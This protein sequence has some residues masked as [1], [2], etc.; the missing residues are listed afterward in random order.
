[1]SIIGLIITSFFVISVE[2]S[3]FR[4]ASFSW[5]P[6]SNGSIKVDYRIS[7]K[8]SRHNC[9]D[10]TI[11]S[12]KKNAEGNVCTTDGDCFKLEYYCTDYSIVDN[13]TSGRNTLY[14]NPPRDK[15][16]LIFKGGDWVVASGWSLLT[17]VDLTPRL[18][19]GLINSSPTVDYPPVVNL[20]Y[21]CQHSIAFPIYD[22]DGDIIRCRWA[23]GK[24]E[25]NSVCRETYN[26]LPSAVLDQN[27][28]KIS[29]TAIDQ[30]GLYPLAIQ[31]EDF[32]ESSP[33]VPLSSIPIQFVVN[34]Y[35]DNYGSCDTVP[36]FVSPTPDPGEYFGV[37][38][39]DQL[40]INITVTG[41]TRLNSIQTT[42]VIGMHRSAVTSWFDGVSYYMSVL[43]TWTPTS[44]A[45]G[46]DHSLCFSG[47]DTNGLYSETRCINIPVGDCG[48]ISSFAN[49]SVH[50][51]N[52]TRHPHMA[53]FDCDVGFKLI[54]DETRQ[55]LANATWSGSYPTCEI[56]ECDD[57]EA[58]KN[59]KI[60]SF[61]RSTIIFECNDGY[62]L[63]GEKILECTINGTW[64]SNPPIC[65][66]GILFNK[67]FTLLYWTTRFMYDFFFIV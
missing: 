64:N 22:V 34:I 1:M 8:R 49:G 46:Q 54:G 27:D 25:C 56:I 6:M 58:P 16:D 63:A 48:D 26:A 47:R 5:A 36:T 61:N 35:S 33:K 55:C 30:V 66:N 39:G 24:T 40:T 43:V 15:F 21:S 44:E 50:T 2:S 7:W 14:I 3:H 13:W 53:I 41:K 67:A 9:D 42:S 57:L 38:V 23:S 59:G 28:C 19:N 10:N 62:L 52:G 20:Q 4:G 65:L 17:T 31:V 37:G 60:S 12:G 51:P 11:A 45:D 32:M 29:Y 18:D